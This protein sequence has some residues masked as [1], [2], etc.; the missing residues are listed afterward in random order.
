VFRF[1]GTSETVVLSLDD[2]DSAF[3]MSDLIRST[4]EHD[5]ELT[6]VVDV[7]IQAVGQWEVQIQ[8]RDPE[9]GSSDTI[10]LFAVTSPWDDDGFW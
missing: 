5:D 10:Q 2:P 4:S 1:C 6:L 8:L 9:T 7:Q 3:G